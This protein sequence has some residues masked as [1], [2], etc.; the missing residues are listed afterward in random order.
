MSPS[1]TQHLGDP[2]AF[3]VD[4]DHRF[5]ARHDEAGD[6]DQIGEADVGGLGDNHQRV[7]RGFLFLRTR[8]VLEPVI[9]G[10][11]HHGDDHSDR[12]LEVFG[13]FHRRINPDLSGETGEHFYSVF[14]RCGYR[15]HRES[16]QINTEPRPI[17]IGTEAPAGKRYDNATNLR[18][19][20]L[21]AVVLFAMLTTCTRRFA[22]AIGWP[23]SL[24]L[25]LPYPTVTRSEPAMPYLSIR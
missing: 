16:R 13:E 18:Q 14:Q 5:P 1:R 3:L 19:A 12:R 4:A 10:P 6:P 7:G 9:A 22:S 2:G 23:G 21:D 24:S 20:Y 15:P 17:A 25:L 8:A 11:Q